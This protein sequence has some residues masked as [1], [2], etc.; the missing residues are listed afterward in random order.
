MPILLAQLRSWLSKPRLTP[1]SEDSKMRPSQSLA[2]MIAA[3][4][5]MLVLALGAFQPTAAAAGVL[6]TGPKAGDMD[7]S[8]F[9]RWDA[10][11][12]AKP[13][14][15]LRT[16]PMP[17][18]PEIT[19]AATGKRLLYTSTDVRWGSGP[20]AVSGALYL[21]KGSP[22]KGGWPLMAWA[23][24]TLGIA[25]V[26]APSWT[27]FRP[28]D[29]TYIDRWLQSGFAVVATDYQGL[30]GPGP[31]PYLYWQAEGRSV[32]D[33]VRAALADEP[34]LISNQVLIAGQSQGGS[35]ALGAARLAQAYAPELKVLGVVATGPNSTFP[36]GPI[37]L[38]VRNS[39]NMFLS[40]ASGGLRDDGPP[41][42]AIATAQGRKLLDIA[43]QACSKEIAMAA[44]ALKIGALSDAFSIPQSQLAAL[45]IPVTDQPMEAIGA[46]I[47]IGTGLADD[48][49]P[50]ARQYAVV[51]ALCASGNTVVW[52][53]YDGLGHDGALHGSFDQSLAFAQ[54][55][56]AG[57][58]APSSC[59]NLSPPAPSGPLKSDAPFNDD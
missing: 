33:S 34:G 4:A 14:A 37:S 2:A 10:A 57:A 1:S 5:I 13:G 58:P 53:R 49:V 36:G 20:I 16:E 51:S 46:P 28:R 31:H 8:P 48:T 59:S 42:E 24:G 56:L 35:A 38:P 45:R 50:T 44:R 30:G 19:A 40:F 3:P 55:L 41:V 23:H 25:D 22:P 21:P 9:Y 12:P 32:L 39:A 6:P 27:G 11:L 15:V 54:A 52:G 17:A 18:Q 7:L 29:A 26:C 47:M 43:R